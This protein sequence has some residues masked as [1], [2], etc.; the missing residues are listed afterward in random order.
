MI[1]YKKMI[2][3]FKKTYYELIELIDASLRP[4]RRIKHVFLSMKCIPSPC[5]GFKACLIAFL[6]ALVLSH[7]A[8][9]M[10]PKSKVRNPSTTTKGSV[11][12]K[13]QGKGLPM[14]LLER[15]RNEFPAA[16][17]VHWEQ[18]K[19]L[20]PA[21]LQAETQETLSHRVRGWNLGQ[22]F[23]AEYPS[24]SEAATIVHT[25]ERP[26]DLGVDQR[27]EILKRWPDQ[28]CIA[29]LRSQPRSGGATYKVLLQNSSSQR[30]RVEG[31][32]SIETNA[33]FPCSDGTKTGRRPKLRTD[34]QR[35]LY[36]LQSCPADKTQP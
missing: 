31:L 17:E 8:E 28:T 22:S 6:L 23:A 13:T 33:I 21:A 35:L 5:F 32:E 27:S 7:R 2:F 9:S 18:R 1:S 4:S 14:S 10:G 11:Y 16:V 24:G 29:V 19:V 26:E 3:L 15:F 34:H 20:G 36:L 30:Y 12:R 25:L